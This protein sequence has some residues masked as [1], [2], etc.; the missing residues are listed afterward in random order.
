MDG[1]NIIHDARAQLLR[2][3]GP[4]SNFIFEKFEG[5]RSE[6]VEKP[7]VGVQS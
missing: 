5:Q 2:K 7:F 4:H 1:F 6:K 3:Y